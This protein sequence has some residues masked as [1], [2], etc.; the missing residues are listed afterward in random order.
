MTLCLFSHKT[1]VVT[2]G[3]GQRTDVIVEATGEPSGVYW[4]RSDIDM[5]CLNMTSTIPNTN[6]NPL[7]RRSRPDCN[8]N[9]DRSFLV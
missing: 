6:S 5:D 9:Y 2:L 8:L 4:M 3:V 1:N 7:L